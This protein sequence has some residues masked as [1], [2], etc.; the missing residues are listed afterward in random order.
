[1]RRSL[2]A[3]ARRRYGK[4]SLDHGGLPGQRD[5]R[6]IWRGTLAQSRRLRRPDAQS[7]TLA[8]QT[9]AQRST[10]GSPVRHF[11]RHCRGPGADTSRGQAARGGLRSVRTGTPDDR[12]T[13][14]LGQATRR[15][16]ARALLSRP[17]QNTNSGRAPS[18]PHRTLR[19][20]AQTAGRCESAPGCAMT[21]ARRRRDRALVRLEGFFG[22]TITKPLRQVCQTPAQLGKALS[23]T[24]TN[25]GGGAICAAVGQVNRD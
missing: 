13:P 21:V 20:L 2:E 10:D 16:G 25:I 14:D 3:L 17:S 6:S 9:R 8:Q 18:A 23:G 22:A 24:L 11:S 7:E 15:R 5:S 19:T 1:M 12:Q 4:H